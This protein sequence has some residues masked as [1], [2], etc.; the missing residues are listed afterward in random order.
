MPTQRSWSHR[1]RLAQAA[2]CSCLGSQK[3]SDKHWA[4]QAGLHLSHSDLTLVRLRP[5]WVLSHALMGGY[6]HPSL[7]IL[8]STLALKKS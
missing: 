4:I 6:S 1:S 3:V 8:T 2:I 7:G 5:S